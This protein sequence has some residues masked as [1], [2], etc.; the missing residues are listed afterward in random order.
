MNDLVL[1]KLDSAHRALAEA[2]TAQEAKRI[3]DVAEA[4][5]VYAQRVGLGIEVINHA[6]HVRLLA[7]RL[8]G[9]MLIAAKKTGQLKP[10]RAKRHAIDSDDSIFLPDDVSLDLSSRAQKF[11]AVPQDGIEAKLNEFAARGEICVTE[12]LREVRGEN[13]SKAKQNLI[14]ELNG[15]PVPPLHGSF[16]VIVI[17]PPW[18]YSS[19]A[20]DNSHRARNPYPDMSLDEIEIL[21][22]AEHSND[23][24]I[25]WLWTTNAFLRAA[26]K[27]MDSWDF[28]QKTMLTWAKDRMGIGD[29]LRGQTEH[30]LLAI[31]GRP[32][33]TLTN[34]TT[35]LVA[36]MR[37]HSRKPDEFYH[38]VESLCPGTKLEMFA[39]QSRPGWQS[40]GLETQKFWN[41]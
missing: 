35:L 33:V 8:L 39:R 11:G 21:P 5:R 36:P 4:A 38:L 1:A 29:W 15:Q 26:F 17:D 41:D 2:K 19:R 37:E 10:G 13:K 12:L 20:Q 18:Q 9:E 16:D 30:C 6:M 24:A 23:N 25:L 7:E 3:A 34:Q 14:A 27:L 40:W 32:I 31:R 28:E 22:V